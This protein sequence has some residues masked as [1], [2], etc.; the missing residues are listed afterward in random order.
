MLSAPVDMC[1]QLRMTY[2]HMPRPE[3]R[4]MGPS[5]QY[6]LVY[7]GRGGTATVQ[8]HVQQNYCGQNLPSVPVQDATIKFAASTRHIA[9]LPG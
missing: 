5:F 1:L 3:S 9:H 7:R 8:I 6:A 2:L 4:V